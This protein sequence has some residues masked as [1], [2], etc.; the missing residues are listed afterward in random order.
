[1]DEYGVVVHPNSFFDL[2]AA[3]QNAKGNKDHAALY[4]ANSFLDP[5][6]YNF[7]RG[8]FS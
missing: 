4:P 7:L 6:G 5:N 2:V 8:E 1:V 3:A